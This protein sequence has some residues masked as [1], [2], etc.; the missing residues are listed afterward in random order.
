M[1]VSKRSH[2]F[3]CRIGFNTKLPGNVRC[4]TP[5]NT[6][7]DV[8]LQYGSALPGRKFYELNRHL[9]SR[10]NR[11]STICGS[12]IPNPIGFAVDGDQESGVAFLY[13]CDSHPPWLAGCSARHF[14]RHCPFCQ[15]Q[16]CEPRDC[17]SFNPVNKT[18]FETPFLLRICLQDILLPTSIVW[19]DPE[20]NPQLLFT[21]R[22][23][24]RQRDAGGTCHV[25]SYSPLMPAI[26]PEGLDGGE[27]ASLPRPF[28]N[29]QVSGA[30]LPVIT[31]PGFLIPGLPFLPGLI[32]PL[33]ESFFSTT[34]SKTSISSWGSD[35]IFST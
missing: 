8:C 11:R 5:E 16:R 4:R 21:T 14:Q 7:R 3:D 26:S 30:E 31:A 29:Q 27:P 28:F 20:E 6:L 13:H 32:G 2:L 15:S 19:F 1:P 22:A 12:N 17:G 23:G 9:A 34:S 10:V 25:I 33:L 18:H 35:W 24:T